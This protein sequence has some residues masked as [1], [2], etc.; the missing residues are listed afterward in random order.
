M[1]NL[2]IE[3]ERAWKSLG[4]VKYGPTESE[5]SNLKLRQSLYISKDM[6]A[7]DVLTLENLRSIRPGL[8]LPSKYFNVLLGCCG[9]PPTIILI[10]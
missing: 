10:F 2:V 8:G 6:K 5:E 9:K 7:G 1:K 3:T 4:Q